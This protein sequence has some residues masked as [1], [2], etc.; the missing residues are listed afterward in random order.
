MHKMQLKKFR[1]MYYQFSLY[2]KIGGKLIYIT[3]VVRLFKKS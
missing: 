1:I 3:K 2:E